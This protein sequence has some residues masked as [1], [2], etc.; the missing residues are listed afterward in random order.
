MKRRDMLFDIWT[1]MSVFL[2]IVGGGIIGLTFDCG[3]RTLPLIG[4][5][6]F[7]IGCISG[8]IVIIKS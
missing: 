1:M 7:T 6:M 3:L 5:A 2:I 8:L 4:C